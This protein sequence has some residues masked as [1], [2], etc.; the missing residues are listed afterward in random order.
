[1][2]KGIGKNLA[3]FFSAA[4]LLESQVVS[5]VLLFLAAQVLLGA[6]WDIGF[7]ATDPMPT[8]LFGF[9]LGL[10]VLAFAGM[11]LACFITSQSDNVLVK[12]II[13]MAHGL[14]MHVTAEGVETEAQCAILRTHGCDEIQGYFFSKPISAKAIEDLFNEGRQLPPHLLQVREPS[15]HLLLDDA[16]DGAGRSCC[17]SSQSSRLP[18]AT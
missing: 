1:M 5:V 8:P 9:G 10:L 11:A 2:S 18:R 17:F 14:G 4:F 13:A 7:F 6:G 12:V 3:Q 15:R 16:P